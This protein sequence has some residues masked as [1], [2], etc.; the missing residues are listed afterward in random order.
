MLSYWTAYLKAHFPAE[1]MAALLTTVGD[2]RD[3]LAVYLNECRRMGIQVLAPDVNESIGFFAAVGEDIRFG[4]G[5]DPQ[6]RRERRR[7]RSSRAREEKG[8][9]PRSTTSSARCRSRSRTSAPSSR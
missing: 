3:K 5:A 4:M 8:A 6:R 7:R 1:Y 2:S 9:S